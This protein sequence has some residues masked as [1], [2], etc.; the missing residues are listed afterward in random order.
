MRAPLNVLSINSEN[1]IDNSNGTN[2]LLGLVSEAKPDVLFVPETS[3][4]GSNQPIE[5]WHSPEFEAFAAEMIRLGY[6]DALFT[7]YYTSARDRPNQTIMSMFTRGDNAIRRIEVG[8]RYALLTTIGGVAVMG[9]HADDNNEVNRIQ[10]AEAITRELEL[11]DSAVIMGDFNAMHRRSIGSQALRLLSWPMSALE[12]RL[13][14]DIASYYDEANSSSIKMASLAVRLTGMADGSSLQIYEKAGFKEQLPLNHPT[15][16][17]G[18]HGLPIPGGLPIDHIL[19]RG[20]SVE[21]I[22]AGV[23]PVEF[24]DHNAVMARFALAS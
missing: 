13:F 10:T 11:Y 8:N 6:G 23:L 14:P 5:E 2:G 20:E 18:G 22:E 4:L 9:V 12:R 21:L 24:S 15:I 19:A 3:K 16:R 1:S 7:D 17:F